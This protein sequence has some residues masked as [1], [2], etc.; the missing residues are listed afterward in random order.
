MATS[1]SRDQPACTA[2]ALVYSGRPDPV[3]PVE[4]L[5]ARKLRAIWKS[6][7]SRDEAPPDVP[8]LGYRG[9]RLHCGTSEWFA[10]GGVV[11][12]GAQVQSDPQQRFEKTLL[13]SAPPGV[14]PERA[15]FQIPR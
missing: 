9:C 7:E 11:T 5:V 12:S 2:I 4:P 1:R 3:W 13:A 14:L 10:F 15:D 8:R 6:L